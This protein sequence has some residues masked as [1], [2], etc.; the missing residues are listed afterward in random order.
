[1]KWPAGSY[2]GYKSKIVLADHHINV[3]YRS[4]VQHG[5]IRCLLRGS[6]QI[7][8]DRPR[9][10]LESSAPGCATRHLCQSWPDEVRPGFGAQKIALT[11]EVFQKTVSRTLVNSGLVANRLQAEAASRILQ[12]F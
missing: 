8:Q 7:R 1:M 6:P 9:R 11:L 10:R 3:Q 2:T 12:G 5:E 4:L